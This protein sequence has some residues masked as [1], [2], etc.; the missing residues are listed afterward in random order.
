M[1]LLCRR[2]NIAKKLVSFVMLYVLQLYLAKVVLVI[3]M[4]TTHFIWS[5]SILLY[6]PQL[7]FTTSRIFF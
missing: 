5:L 3:Y 1:A 7:C 6:M 4:D 2:I